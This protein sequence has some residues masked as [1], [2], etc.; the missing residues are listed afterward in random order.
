MKE[1]SF[2]AK[3]YLVAVYCVGCGMFLLNLD[4]S[5]NSNLLMLFALSLLGS[6]LHIYKVVGATVRSHYTFSFVVYGFT[7]AH[8]GIGEM[9]LVILISNLAEWVWNK[10]AWFIQ[11]FNITCYFIAASGAFLA[12]NLVNPS[13][14]FLTALGV[15]SIVISMGVFTFLNHFLLGIILW[16]ARGENFKVSRMGDVFPFVMDTTLLMFGCVL[17]VVWEYSPYATFN[18]PVPAVFD[19]QHPENSRPRKTNGNRPKD[20]SVQPQ[21]LHGAHHKR[22]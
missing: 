22:A 9:L 15:L 21:I 2:P 16:L 1:L 19:L 5:P 4:F 8:F 17:N 7:F 18:F 14:S 6:V 3:I 10:P 13:G 12:F 20:R 11:V